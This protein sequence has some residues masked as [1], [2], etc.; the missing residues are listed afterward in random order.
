MDYNVGY[1]GDERLK[2]NGEFLVKAMM[3]KRTVNLRQ[4]GGDRAKEVKFG[5][6]LSNKKVMSQ[7]LIKNIVEKTGSLV[8]GRRV[9]AIQD[10]TEI[11]YQAHA[12]RV[13][14]LGTVGNG[15]DVG[16]FLHPALI[17]DAQEETCLGIGAIKSWMRTE[18]AREDYQKQLIE[19][20]ESYRWIETAEQT[21]EILSLAAEITVIA[22][23]ESDIYEEWCRI[24]DEK[25]HL[26]TRACRDR[27]LANGELLFNYISKLEVRGVYEFEVNERVGKRSAHKARLE[28]RFGEIEIRK[29]KKCTDKSAPGSIKLRIVDVKEVSETIVGE[30]EAIHWSLLTTHKIETTEAALQIVRWYCLRWNIEQ[31]FRTLK[32]QGLDIESSQV[33]TAEGLMKIAIVALFVALQ[34]MQLMLAREGKEQLI[35]VVFNEHECKVLSALQKKLEGKTQKQKNSHSPEKLSWAAWTIARLGGWKGYK[36]ESPPGPITMLRGLKSFQSLFQGYQLA[37]MCA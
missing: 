14:G 8:V 21:K 6:W 9:L 28:I 13:R 29:P 3:E 33:E 2:K 37:E 16:F 27:K 25:T 1:F 35:S 22:D 19:E 36:S 10:T 23:R 20:K 15:K 30:E 26:I 4:L 24:P 11:N 12:K 7:E 17:V 34:S 18:P 32:K 5:R 31:L